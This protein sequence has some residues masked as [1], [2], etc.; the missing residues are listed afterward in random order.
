MRRYFADRHGD[1]EVAPLAH[2]P[3]FLGRELSGEPA[4]FGV[5]SVSHFPASTLYIFH[6]YLSPQ[7]NSPDRMAYGR[8]LSRERWRCTSRFRRLECRF[9]DR[10][11]NGSVRR[12]TL[13]GCEL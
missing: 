5:G 7:K 2:V 10:C 13:R 11:I 3:N 8:G 1:P 9:A 4:P 12:I 6:S